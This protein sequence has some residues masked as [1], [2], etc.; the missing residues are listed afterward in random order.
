V[1]GTGYGHFSGL[2]KVWKYLKHRTLYNVW[3]KNILNARYQHQYVLYRGR[4]GQVEEHLK[5]KVSTPWRPRGTRREVVEEHLKCKVSTPVHTYRIGGS[6]VEEH[7]KCKVSTPYQLTITI[8]ELRWKNILNARYQ[9]LMR[10][11][12]SFSSWWKNILNAR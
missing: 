5:C 6:Q 1:N 11:L 7:L 3:W 9:H 8:I 10:C 4:D 2:K 12:V